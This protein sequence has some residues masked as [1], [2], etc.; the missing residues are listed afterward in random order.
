[1]HATRYSLANATAQWFADDHPGVTFT[2]MEK[3]LWHSTETSGWP[4][5]GGGATAPN[6]TA[7]PDQ[8]AKRL[9]WRQHFP[10]NMS[11][12][13]LLHSHTQP[14]N[15]DHVV[16]IEL[17]G[18]C[19]PGGPGLFWPTAPDWALAGIADFAAW[20]YQEWAVPLRSTVTWRAYGASDD[21]QRLSD[22]AYNG[23]S[24]HLGHEH[25]PQNDHRDPGALAMA[26]AL[27]IAT[28]RLST[29]GT[30]VTP[31]EIDAVAQ[32]TF[33]KIFN[34][35]VPGTGVNFQTVIS[36]VYG[37]GILLEKLVKAGDANDEIDPKVLAAAIVA[38]L[39]PQLPANVD[40]KA[41]AVAVADEL[42]NRL[43]G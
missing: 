22:S 41:V 40:V 19:V 43:A 2:S 35:T 12:R 30:T 15:G 33:E 17:V 37:Q 24:G 13:A 7:T 11:S 9:V 1:M 27:T 32:R 5:Y 4:G 18:T 36:R 3:C 34:Y 23:Y 42:R 39:P 20:L 29:G 8:S 28:S 38:G 6:F 16:Q 25:A 21:W 26:R 14:T 10:V 31:D